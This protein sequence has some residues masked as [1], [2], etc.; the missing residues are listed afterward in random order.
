MFSP[1]AKSLALVAV[2]S[3]VGTGAYFAWQ[4]HGQVQTAS[5]DASAVQAA[6]TNP[7]SGSESTA[8]SSKPS[9][10][11]PEPA[12]VVGS[13]PSPPSPETGSEAPAAAPSIPAEASAPARAASA[14]G[15]AAVTNGASTSKAALGSAAHDAPAAAV[16]PVVTTDSLAEE[17]TLLRQADRALRAGNPSGALDLLDQHAARFPKGVLSAERNGERMIARC[18]LGQVNAGA[19]DAYLSA[20]PQSALSARIRDACAKAR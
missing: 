11:V 5:T 19:R 8:A 9:A 4:A 3:S 12:A 1:V 2:V 6:R 16:P 18:Q 14:R 17:T 10:F 13:A 20:H 7:K 15:Q